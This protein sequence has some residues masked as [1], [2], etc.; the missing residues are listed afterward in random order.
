M[1]YTIYL[2]L[3]CTQYVASNLPFLIYKELMELTSFIEIFIINR[4]F[5]VLKS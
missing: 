1:F 4:N 2:H 5:I 3:C